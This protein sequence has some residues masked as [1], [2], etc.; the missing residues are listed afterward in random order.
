MNARLRRT[1]TSLLLFVILGSG[2][3]MMAHTRVTLASAS[4][5]AAAGDVETIAHIY[6][7]VY[8]YELPL[9]IPVASGVAKEANTR[10]FHVLSDDARPETVTTMILNDARELGATHVVDMQTHYLSSWVQWLVVIWLTEAEGSGTA[11]RVKSGAAPP[12]AIAVPAAGA[13]D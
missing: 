7:N 12:G 2:G 5:Q 8:G 1:I 9:G 11:I 3:C 13:Q 10:G 6:A 4:E